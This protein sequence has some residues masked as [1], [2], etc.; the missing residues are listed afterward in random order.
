MICNLKIYMKLFLNSYD[1]L[2]FCNCK[3][4]KSDKFCNACYK[5]QSSVG[6]RFSGMLRCVCVCVQKC[7]VSYYILLFMFGNSI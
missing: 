4:N 7:F 3:S 1:S 2:K 6:H 5:Y